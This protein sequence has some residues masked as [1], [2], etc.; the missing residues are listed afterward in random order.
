MILKKKFVFEVR[1]KHR[2]MKKLEDKVAK[3]LLR[4][5]FNI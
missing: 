3:Y 4:N 5:I 1:T 2:D